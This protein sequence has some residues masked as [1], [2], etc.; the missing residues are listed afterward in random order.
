MDDIHM[1]VN[2]DEFYTC[3]DKSDYIFHNRFNLTNME[4]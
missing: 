3:I 1:W 4:I 2:D